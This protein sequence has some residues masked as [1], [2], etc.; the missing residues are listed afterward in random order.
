MLTPSIRYSRVL[1]LACAY[2]GI[3][4]SSGASALGGEQLWRFYADFGVSVL[5]PTPDLSGNGGM[6][7][8]VGAADDT[9]YLV[10]GKGFKGG[11][12]LWAAPFRSTI[13]AAA[14]IGDVDGDGRP[15]VAAG[16]ELGFVQLISGG[17]GNPIWQ[18]LTFGTVLSLISIP[19]VDGDGKPETVF[20]SEDDTVYCMSSKA[21]GLGVAV[22]KF[23]LPV[24][25][26]HPGPGG[27]SAAKSA[28]KSAAG[29]SNSTTAVGVNSLALIHNGTAAQGIVVGSSNDT[30]YCL[31]TGGGAPKWKT[32]LPGD[33]WKVV[34][35]PDQDGDGIEEVL[36]ACGADTAYLLKGSDGT[37]LWS[38]AVSMGATEVAASP[39]ADGDG[40][41]DALIGDGAGQVHCVSGTARGANVAASWTFNFGDNS[42]IQSIAALGDIDGDGRSECV[43]GTSNDTVAIVTG[44]GKQGWSVNVGGSVPSVC[45][46]GDLDGNGVVDVAAGSEMGFAALF[47]GGGVP[48]VS[49]AAPGLA[50]SGRNG[51][52]RSAISGKVTY[53]LHLDAPARIR[54][55]I[56]DDRGRLVA[57]PFLGLAPAGEQALEWNAPAANR[58]FS[59]RLV[60]DG[61]TVSTEVRP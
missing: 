48:A 7:L 12:P 45:S 21:K 20:G 1:P 42:T 27:Q 25:K 29:R 10:E 43:V 52:V 9:L 39:D 3:L 61:K 28:A 51:P 32:G 26:T 58:V 22:W 56:F 30:V 24:G 50:R 6:D 18:Y 13:S 38:H 16:D 44:K 15:D 31:P 2:A 14:T 60:V 36:L 4:F 8:L 34:A 19:D 23:G 35:F 41:P 33:I 57:T 5:S 37:M 55:E 49:L 40:K 17:T 59:S 53:A 54:W 46:L 47:S 11:A